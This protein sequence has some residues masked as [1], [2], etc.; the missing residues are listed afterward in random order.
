MKRD[1]AIELVRKYGAAVEARDPDGMVDR[2]MALVETLTS[3]QPTTELGQLYSGG[4][5]LVRPD[6]T[7]LEEHYPTKEW[8]E[9]RQRGGGKV[10][11]RT[12]IVV[13]DWKLVRKRKRRA[14]SLPT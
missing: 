13:E 3:A 12:I 9:H 2:G 5:M 4:S 6:W 14:S 11:R 10:Y 1:E 8:I 7:D